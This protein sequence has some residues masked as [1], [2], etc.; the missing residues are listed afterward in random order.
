M[1]FVDRKPGTVPPSLAYALADEKGE[2]AKVRAA[3]PKPPAAL[4]PAKSYDFKA[5]KADDVKRA[6]ESLFHDKCAYCE[7]HHG[8]GGPV[9]IE[10]F[11][12]KGGVLEDDA[13]PGYWWL[14]MAW[15]NLLYSCLDCNRMRGQVIVEP[16]MTPTQVELARQRPR[17]SN[18][19]KKDSFPIQ[20]VRC[21]PEASDLA[22]EYALL[23]DPTLIRPENH[24]T[25]FAGADDRCL[26][27]AQDTPRGPDPLGATSILVFGLNRSALV[28][29]R[30][31]LW[32][33]LRVQA[34][35]IQEDLDD[36]EVAETEAQEQKALGRAK[37]RWKELE[38]W[39]T[40]EQP[41]SAMVTVFL[42][43]LKA[44]IGWD[45]AG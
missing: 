32:K 42:A 25:F 4:K 29:A 40:P 12:P 37:R 31:M 36:Y 39:A 21:Q 35:F 45:D 33:K 28:D 18:A 24:L 10:H 14:A 43:R 17:R 26:A 20:G 22:S 9:D 2:L 30:S 34:E 44:E 3:Y 11:R 27:V 19:G 41:Y 23:I 38:S 13:H 15:E 6:I 8:A 5:Y 1:I 7:T 16:G